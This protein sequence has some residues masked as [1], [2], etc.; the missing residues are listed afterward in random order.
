MVPEAPQNKL[1]FMLYIQCSKLQDLK[2]QD[3]AKE[4]ISS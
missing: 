3:G 4:W 1:E 2:S